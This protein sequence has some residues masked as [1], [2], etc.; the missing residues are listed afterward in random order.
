MAEDTGSGAGAIRVEEQLIFS[1]RL[2]SRLGGRKVVTLSRPLPASVLSG[3]RYRKGTPTT[4]KAEMKRGGREGKKCKKMEKVAGVTL[5]DSAPAP[6]PTFAPVAAVR[7]AREKI[8]AVGE[9]L[10]E[11][12]RAAQHDVQ[13][14]V[15]VL[16]AKVQI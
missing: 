14:W 11:K 16:K 5:I 1:P 12:A 10:V 3:R 4:L 13:A 2:L 9:G 6:A 8:E 15:A 7:V